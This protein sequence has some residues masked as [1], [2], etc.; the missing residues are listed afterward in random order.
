[1]EKKHKKT[2]AERT[3]SV[4]VCACV[5]VHLYFSVCGVCAI[6]K[7]SIFGIYAK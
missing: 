5:C 4:S 6:Y 1:M 3:V 7:L 2:L